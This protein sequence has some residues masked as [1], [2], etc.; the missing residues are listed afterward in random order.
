MLYVLRDPQG[1]ILSLHR[2]PVEGGH[3]IAADHPDVVAFLGR[4][5]DEQQFAS[6]DA[7]LVRV[8][9]DLIDVLIRRNILCVTDLPPEAQAKLFDRKHFR[10]GMQSHSLKLFGDQGDAGS[11]QASQ[12]DAM[13][14][15]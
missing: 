5:P 10:E 12:D 2:A 15:L 1:E 11:A 4:S 7:G 13:G 6:L 3:S 9:E 8:L 14:K